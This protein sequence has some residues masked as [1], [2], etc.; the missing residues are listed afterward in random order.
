MMGKAFSLL[1]EIEA[2]NSLFQT[3]DAGVKGVK[4]AQS[5][6]RPFDMCGNHGKVS[7]DQ[8]LARLGI[9]VSH[10]RGKK[11]LLIAGQ[12]LNTLGFVEKILN[13]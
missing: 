7:L 9:V 11:S 3:I 10:P 13:A 12:K 6:G 4:G 1:K 8:H 2:I 5:L